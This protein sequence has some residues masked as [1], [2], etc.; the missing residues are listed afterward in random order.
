[1]KSSTFEG[2]IIIQ[3]ILMGLF[4]AR[5]DI[6]EA[7]LTGWLTVFCALIVLVIPI[8]I[9]YGAIKDAIKWIIRFLKNINAKVKD[10]FGIDFLAKLK[11]LFDDGVV[12]E[13]VFI[14]GIFV[15]WGFVM[16]YLRVFIKTISRILA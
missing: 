15:I 6:W 13:I 11:Y 12:L 5:P 1:M 14:M 3:L 9:L 8:A 16:P 10:L 4:F 7:I 2:V